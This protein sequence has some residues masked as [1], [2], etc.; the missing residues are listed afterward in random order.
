[1]SDA[2][3][4]SKLLLRAEALV[5]VAP[6]KEPNWDTF[7]ARIEAAL[8]SAGPTDDSLLFRRCPRA[9]KTAWAGSCR[10]CRAAIEA[11]SAPR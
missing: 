8:S 11:T 7:A 4:E 5:A 10:R 3:R 6:L 9:W 1:M 2:E